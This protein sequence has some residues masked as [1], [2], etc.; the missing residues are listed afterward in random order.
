MKDLLF[1]IAG[2]AAAAH[3]LPKPAK[4]CYNFDLTLTVTSE[5]FIFASPKFETNFDVTD[6]I[7]DLTSRSPP[8]D[9]ATLL[10]GKVNQTGIY[11]ISSTFC[12]PEDTSAA[13]RTTVLLATHGLNFDRKYISTALPARQVLTFNFQ[14]YWNSDLQPER[15]NFVDYAI[16]QGYSVFYY[17][18]LGVGSSSM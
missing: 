2:T 6:F 17:D 11:T 7:T 16:N 1:L 4:L 9:F 18:R 5:N 13:K 15:Y 12:T 3:Y 10:P 8:K 14:S